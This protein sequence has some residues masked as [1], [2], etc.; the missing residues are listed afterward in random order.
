VECH[1][2]IGAHMTVMY[3]TVSDLTVDEEGFS[4]VRD[5]SREYLESM[6]RELSILAFKN[7]WDSLAIIFEMARREAKH[8]G[9]VANDRFDSEEPL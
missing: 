2:S 5:G 3:P 8:L 4:Q 9:D 7:G 1:Y 6:S